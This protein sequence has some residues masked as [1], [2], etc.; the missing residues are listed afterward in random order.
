MFTTPC[1][2][3]DN[4]DFDNTIFSGSLLNKINNCSLYDINKKYKFI[5]N[6]FYDIDLIRSDIT[7]DDIKSDESLLTKYI[8]SENNIIEI[9]NSDL[10]LLSKYY[11]KMKFKIS[12]DVISKLNIN[13]D[14]KMIFREKSFHKDI[15]KT[16]YNKNILDIYDVINSF[17]NDLF[18][19]I[20]LYV[21]YFNNTDCDRS[22]IE[23]LSDKISLKNSSETIIKFIRLLTNDDI[24]S[25]F[26]N[27]IL[28]KRIKDDFHVSSFIN[29]L[30]Y[31]QLYK[32][33]NYSDISDNIYKQQLTQKYNDVLYYNINNI[34][35]IPKEL[36]TFDL[37][38]KIKDNK[39]LL[40]YFDNSKVKKLLLD[41]ITDKLNQLSIINNI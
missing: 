19:F 21:D 12:P 22:L 14:N 29:E 37:Y 38:N 2:E 35:Y 33:I 32:Y 9:F 25:E 36:H 17:S 31:Y 7:I 24:K 6:G 40:K 18:I 23:I 15:I 10:S 30:F 41:D 28:S 11:D 26:V 34:Q 13:S 1:V 3:L 27:R 16:L 8:I 5:H 20:Y 39:D 4:I